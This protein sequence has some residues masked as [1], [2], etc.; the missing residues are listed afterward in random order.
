VRTAGIELG[1]SLNEILILKD[2]RIAE[3]EDELA[4]HVVYLQA[5]LATVDWMVRKKKPWIEIM[6]YLN[7][8]PVDVCCITEEQIDAAWEFSKCFLGPAR[9]NLK[10]LLSLLGIVACS[11]CGGSGVYSSGDPERSTNSD[12]PACHRNGKSHGWVWAEKS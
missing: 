12:C 2:V 3:L 1:K 8:R 11:E 6:E 9:N 4:P 5:T 7:G 10:K